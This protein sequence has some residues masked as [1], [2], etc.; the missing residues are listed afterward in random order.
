M[1]LT[2]EDFEAILND[3]LMESIGFLLGT[4]LTGALL[5]LG[6][7]SFFLLSPRAGDGSLLRPNCLLRAYIIILL[8]TVLAFDAGVLLVVNETAI[9]N[10]LSQPPDTIQKFKG[11]LFNV[12]GSTTMVVVLLAD[13]VLVRLL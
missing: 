1:R 2:T 8:L 9:F 5:S 7:H 11:M 12:V 6:I 4:L 10:F 3:Q 13:G